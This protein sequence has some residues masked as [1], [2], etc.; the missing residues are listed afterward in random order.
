MFQD[1]RW[2]SPTAE[3]CTRHSCAH[4]DSLDRWFSTRPNAKPQTLLFLTLGL[5]YLGGLGIYIATGDSLYDSFWQASPDLLLRRMSST[6]S[7][8]VQ[9]L[10][11][12]WLQEKQGLHH[13][14]LLLAL[15]LHR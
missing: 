14:A 10:V 6:A 13:L 5:I 8:V 7:S 2:L 9:P 3:R 12:Y 15:Q 4:A 1:R 11:A